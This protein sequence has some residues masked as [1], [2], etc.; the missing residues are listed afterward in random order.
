MF[1]RVRLPELVRPLC[2]LSH[3]LLVHS[4]ALGVIVMSE[5]HDPWTTQLASSGGSRSLNSALAGIFTDKSVCLWAAQMYK[6]SDKFIRVSDS[7]VVYSL[8]LFT[9]HL[10]LFPSCNMMDS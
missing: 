2:M 5:V 10:T 4:A 8:C 9:Y 6:C 3:T 1:R 7:S